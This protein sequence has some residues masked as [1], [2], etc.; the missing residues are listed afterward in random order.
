MDSILMLICLLPGF[1]VYLFLKR[2]LV[3]YGNDDETFDKSLRSLLFNIPIIF[4]SFS[5]LKIDTIC[6]LIFSKNNVVD[7]GTIEEIKSLISLKDISILWLLA[8]VILSTFI[9]IGIW[10]LTKF[11]YEQWGNKNKNYNVFNYKNIYHDYFTKEQESIPVELFGIDSNELISSG[12]VCETSN[13][14]MRNDI[15][16]IIEEEELFTN[17]KNRGFLVLDKTYLDYKNNMKI[18]IYKEKED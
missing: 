14:K 8:L 17:A 12:Y 11:I 10:F 6:N 13:S 16:M 9:F 15:E 3:G 1:F 7:V 4:I 2:V 5:I 18:L